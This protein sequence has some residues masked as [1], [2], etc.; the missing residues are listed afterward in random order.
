MGDVKNKHMSAKDKEAQRLK[1][2]VAQE[3]ALASNKTRYKQW[4]VLATSPI[5]A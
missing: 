4:H 5:L 3:A 2:K 1:R